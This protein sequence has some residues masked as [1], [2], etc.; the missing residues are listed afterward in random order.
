M[1]RPK[2]QTLKGYI[3]ALDSMDFTGAP[4]RPSPQ[5]IRDIH[6]TLRETFLGGFVEAFSQKH[7]LDLE[8]ICCQGAVIE[9]LLK[10]SKKNPAFEAL[11][12]IRDMGRAVAKD[13]DF[14]EGVRQLTEFA[15][16]LAA[17][18]KDEEWARYYLEGLIPETN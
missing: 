5:Q 11:A 18:P 2:E 17:S 14:V 4:D 6:E 3:E 10:T 7:N 13:M 9:H 12:D 1:D 16:Y 8:K 15:R